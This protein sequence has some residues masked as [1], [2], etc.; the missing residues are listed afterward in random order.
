MILLR[1]SGSGRS[2]QVNWQKLAGERLSSGKVWQTTGIASH[3]RLPVM[4][5]VKRWQGNDL[6][7]VSYVVEV[8]ISPA[9]DKLGGPVVESNL[10]SD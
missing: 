5:V 7:Q 10:C 8:W 2:V 6:L 9:G 3:G 1:K 4:A